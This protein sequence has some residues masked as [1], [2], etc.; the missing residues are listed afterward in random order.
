M[1]NYDIKIVIKDGEADE[2]IKEIQ[3]HTMKIGECY[4]RLRK[5]GVV[6][7]EK[8][9]S[10]NADG[11]VQRRGENNEDILRFHRAPR[12]ADADHRVGRYVDCCHIVDIVIDP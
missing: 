6:V 2:I 11:R 4:D 1:R 8:A 9:V 3:E 7:V 5:L 10:E 12:T